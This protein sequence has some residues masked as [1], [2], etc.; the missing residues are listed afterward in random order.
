MPPPKSESLRLFRVASGKGAQ[1]WES[2]EGG[3]CSQ[4]SSKGERVLC[5]CYLGHGWHSLSGSSLPT[6]PAPSPLQTGTAIP[7][8][9]ATYTITASRRWVHLLPARLTGIM[10]LES[11][12]ATRNPPWAPSTTT[13]TWNSSLNLIFS[14]RSQS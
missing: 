4:K 13:D 11:A 12:S 8:P 6:P 9:T 7:S 14:S 2:F 5:A 1:G 10:A 3:G